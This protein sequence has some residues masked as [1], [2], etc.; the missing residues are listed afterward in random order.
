MGI[1]ERLSPF[2]LRKM[3]LSPRTYI[4]EKNWTKLIRTL[5]EGVNILPAT[6][7]ANDSSSLKQICLRENKYDTPYRYVPSIN[8]NKVTITKLR[9]TNDGES[10][11]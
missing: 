2:K 11:E 6:F 9:R 7:G 4:R 5:P 3:T 10:V 1:V 8:G